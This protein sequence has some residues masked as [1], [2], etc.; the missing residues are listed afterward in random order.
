MNESNKY[1]GLFFRILES[2]FM[3]KS[4]RLN[5]LCV[6]FEIWVK[7]FVNSDCGVGLCHVYIMCVW[8]VEGENV[9]LL[10]EG[11]SSDGRKV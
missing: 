4:G 1:R 11:K 7:K 2:L 5:G 6:G 3:D 8:L 10:L 9:H